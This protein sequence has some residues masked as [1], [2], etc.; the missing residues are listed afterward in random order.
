M[1]ILSE[2]KLRNVSINECSKATG[3]PYGSLYP[4]VHGKKSLEKC[5]YGTLKKLADFLHYEPEDFFS[6]PE[7]FTVYWENEKTA[8]VQIKGSQAIIKRYCK[9]P[10]KQ[11]FPGNTI[12]LYELGDIM[13]W[14]CW[15]K[16]RENIEKYLF[17][18]GLTEFNPYKICRKTH[19]AMFQDKIWFKYE[20]EKLTWEDVKCR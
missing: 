18:L 11:I 8:E 16:N 2:L 13:T 17:K 1:D 15:D 7:N 20:G 4:L 10:A 5:E 14:R 6:Q 9:N 19:G 3:I 12:S